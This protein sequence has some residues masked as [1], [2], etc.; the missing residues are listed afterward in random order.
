MSDHLSFVFSVYLWQKRWPQCAGLRA[1]VS[2]EDECCC[3]VALN[4]KFAG[5]PATMVTGHH[6]LF[7][8]TRQYM[9]WD[10]Y[11]FIHK[12]CSFLHKKQLHLIIFQYFT[13]IKEEF[14]QKR[15]NWS[16]SVPKEA[17]APFLCLHFLAANSVGYPLFSCF[18]YP[19]GTGYTA[20][21]FR[22]PTG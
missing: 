2:S 7:F 17:V 14:M 15:R 19:T 12:V 18:R 1:C 11:I 6:H 8:L 9:F 22:Y 5:Y 13:S 3:I 4:T 16:N 21:H 10:I 20:S